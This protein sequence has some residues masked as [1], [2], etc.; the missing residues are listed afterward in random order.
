LRHQTEDLVAQW[1]FSEP[2]RRKLIGATF[3]RERRRVILNTAG[4]YPNE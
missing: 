3:K 2:A 1:N 4:E